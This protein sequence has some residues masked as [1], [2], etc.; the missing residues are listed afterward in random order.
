MN[1]TFSNLFLRLSAPTWNPTT[2]GP[3]QDHT[4]KRYHHPLPPPLQPFALF[5][6]HHLQKRPDRA[7]YEELLLRWV[8]LCEGMPALY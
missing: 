8:E 6:E 5:A 2:T 3:P 7:Q 4:D 1:H